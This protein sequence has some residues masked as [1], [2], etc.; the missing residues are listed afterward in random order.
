M[1]KVNIIGAGGF[2]REVRSMLPHCDKVLGDLYDD[3]QSIGG[4]SGPLN[5]CVDDGVPYVIAVGDSRLRKNIFDR[6][7]PALKYEVLVHPQ[8]ILQEKS[9]INIAKG[10]I[11]TAGCILTCDI[12]VDQFTLINLNCTIGHG[13]RI[14]SFSS[15]MPS[16]NLGGEVHLEKTV[17]V[18]TGAT[19]LPGVRIG[20][21]AIIGAGS[22]VTRDVE[23]GAIVRGIPARAH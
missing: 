15:L 11:V 20:N 9:S 3:D 7:P 2:G 14:G 19:I 12:E 4:V 6:L 1:N 13:V 22:V 18:G 17:Y 10:C 8:A 16:V 21:N 5:S 23:P